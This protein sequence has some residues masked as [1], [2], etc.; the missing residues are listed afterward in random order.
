VR[1]RGLRRAKLALYAA[2][3]IASLLGT[4]LLAHAALFGDFSDY[5][6]E[7][8]M[9]LSLRA[10]REGNPL[11]DRVPTIYGPF[12]FQ[13]VSAV[14]ALLRLP[15]DNAG[16]RWFALGVWIVASLLCGAW[17]WRRHRSFLAALLAW[18]LAFRTLTLLTKEPLHPGDLIVLLLAVA[19]HVALGLSE[20]TPKLSTWVL[21]GALTAGVGL[22]K[23]N[24]GAFLLVA[25]LASWARFAER[26]RATRLALALFLIA[27]PFLLMRGRLDLGWVREFAILVAASLAPFGILLFREP[28]EHSWGKKPLVAFLAGGAALVLLSIAFLFVD[29]TTP[30][31]LWRELVVAAVKFPAQT[32]LEPELPPAWRGSLSSRSGSSC[33][34]GRAVQAAPRSPPSA[35]PPLSTRSPAARCVRCRWHRCPSSGSSRCP[36][37]RGSARRASGRSSSSR[38][39][40]LCNPCTRS[41]SPAA[42]SRSS[43]SS[44]RSSPSPGSRTPGAISRSRGARACR[45][46]CGR[47]ASRSPSRPA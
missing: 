23:T 15:L 5:D 35:P 39:R 44:C 25:V 21:L 19:A 30:A 34:R 36:V 10:W 6:D 12:Y 40:S 9:L 45:P 42:R 7:G 32:W 46:G 4:A 41:P 8:Y 20:R 18:A 28:G 16:A 33:A 24:V 13:F 47:R 31:G 22:S 14:F 2:I 29:G 17:A 1:E 43:R 3:A 27:L 11:Y 26:G 37:R 38:S